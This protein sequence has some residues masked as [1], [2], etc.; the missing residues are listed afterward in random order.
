MQIVFLSFR[1]FSPSNR[2]HPNAGSRGLR[3]VYSEVYALEA[4]H[5]FVIVEH[6]GRYGIK[7]SS[8]Y[9]MICSCCPRALG[10]L[11]HFLQVGVEFGGAVLGL[12]HASFEGAMPIGFTGRRSTLCVVMLM[13][14][15]PASEIVPACCAQPSF[16][17]SALCTE[18]IGL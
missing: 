17:R 1:P 3:S 2:G 15:N 14:K 8:P 16:L 6:S 18:Q 13:R 5:D 7:N 11:A 4:T 12:Y 10:V 9:A